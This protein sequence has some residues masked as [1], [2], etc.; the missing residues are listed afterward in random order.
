LPGN[1][2]DER[3]FAVERRGERLERRR[4]GRQLLAVARELELRIDADPPYVG[5]IVDVQAREVARLIRR[6]EGAECPSERIVGRR[7]REVGEA[8][9]FWQKLAADDAQRQ[10]RVAALQKP[11]GPVDGCDVAWCTGEKRGDR[12]RH[13][14]A[15]APRGTRALL[16]NVGHLCNE[17]R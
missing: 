1:G 17:R 8:R 13:G 2:A 12:R 7:R 14:H 4:T 15:I 3:R 11:D 9:A 10:A 16:E 6:A 5:Q